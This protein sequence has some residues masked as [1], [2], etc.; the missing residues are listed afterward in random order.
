[1][2]FFC[3]L[4]ALI[5]G[6]HYFGQIGLKNVDQVQEILLKQLWRRESSARQ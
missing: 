5:I 6:L 3:W 4:I 1:M 2:I